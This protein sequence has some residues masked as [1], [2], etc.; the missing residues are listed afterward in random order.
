MAMGGCGVCDF[1]LWLPVA[2]LSAATVGL[3]DDARFPGRLI[4]SAHEHF[5][6]LDDMAPSEL[7]EFMAGVQRACR[8][9]RSLEGVE[10]VNVAILGNREPHVHAHL[11]PRRAGEP[12]SGKAPWDGAAPRKTLNTWTRLAL[13]RELR[14][15]L[16]A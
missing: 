12:N 16:A 4:V 11:I 9:L 2:R 3:Y 10:R 8:A 14:G 1:A 15:L 13:T 7:G 5:E 6:H